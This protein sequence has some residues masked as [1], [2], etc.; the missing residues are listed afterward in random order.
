MRRSALVT[1]SAGFVGRHMTRHLNASGWDVRGID[2][3]GILNA[4]MNDALDHFMSEDV[5]FD[6]VVHAAAAGPNRKA[7]D[8]RAGNFPYNVLLDSAMFEWAIRTKQRHVV[9][10]SS[11]A[12]YPI[13]YQR[14]P[15][16]PFFLSE[17]LIKLNSADEPDSVYGWTKLTGERMAVATRRC[18]VPVTVVRPFSGYGTDQSKD[19]PFRAFIDRALSHSD[20]FTVWGSVDQARDWIHIDDIV[21]G[22]MTLVEQDAQS[23]HHAVNLCTGESTTMGDLVRLICGAVWYSPNISVDES[24]PTGVMNRVGDPTLLHNFY[25]P[26]ILI[27]EGVDRALRGKW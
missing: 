4:G 21:R 8:T 6:L 13:K 23:Q 24:A 14:D 1:G 22:V 12:A 3:L 11:A 7:I 15:Y 9:Y 27:D 17:D 2:I 10:F 26:R 16:T 25:R 18:G 5:V 19:F 20:P